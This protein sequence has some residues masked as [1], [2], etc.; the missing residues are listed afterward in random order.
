MDA[1]VVE[2]I[3]NPRMRGRKLNV[4]SDEVSQYGEEIDNPRMRGRKPCGLQRGAIPALKKLIIP[5]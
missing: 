1:A 4:V 3:D 2:E 5:G